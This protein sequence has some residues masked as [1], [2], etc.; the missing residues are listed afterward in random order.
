MADEEVEKKV[1]IF[2]KS[3]G[4]IPCFRDSYFYGICTGFV[5]GLGHFMF[6]SK[7]G[8]STHVGM[9]AFC[10]STLTYWS[11]C[12]WKHNEQIKQAALIKAFL[13]EGFVKESGISSNDE[14]MIA[15]V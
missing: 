9:G 13:Q 10:I 3:I 14:D 8:L 15:S 2:G 1:S 7:P 4:E 6:T 11:Y 5:S 12:R